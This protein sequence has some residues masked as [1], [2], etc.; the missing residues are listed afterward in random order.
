MGSVMIWMYTLR[1]QLARWPTQ[2][3]SEG[4]DALGPNCF[5]HRD[6]VAPIPNS[7]EATLE[8]HKPAKF[9]FAISHIYTRAIGFVVTVCCDTVDLP[10]RRSTGKGCVLCNLLTIHYL[11]QLSKHSSRKPLVTCLNLDRA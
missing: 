2:L 5:W 4:G 6:G 7:V 3:S 9:L 10:G 11:W 1:H 8:A